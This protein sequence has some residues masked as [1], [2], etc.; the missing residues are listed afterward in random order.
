MDTPSKPLPGVGSLLSESWK[1]F[2]ST[3]NTSVKT[4]A[5]LLIAPALTL[6]FGLVV[7]DKMS[8]IPLLIVF[9]IVQGIIF[10]WASIRLMLTMLN[11]EGGKP[12]MAPG[13]ESQK[14]MS[15]LLSFCWIAFLVGL[16]TL[17]ATLLLILPGIYFNT[18]LTFSALILLDQ[19]KRGTQ[20]LAAS[21]ALV[22]GRWWDTFLNIFVAGI[23]FGLP[24]A[25]LSN[26]VGSMMFFFT[27]TNTQ[28]TVDAV[29]F[30]SYLVVAATMP[31]IM[32]FQIKL[33][34]ALQRTR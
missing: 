25:L 8:N 12:V 15:L 6:A 30:V 21:R 17:G 9:A 24:I 29:N 7:R 20:A 23:V 33:Y 13:E 5:L 11:L 2:T 22:K 27:R 32:G 1:L 31:L 4:S 16:V 19:G 26:A 28:F 34:R 3:W 10:L 18:A 14:A